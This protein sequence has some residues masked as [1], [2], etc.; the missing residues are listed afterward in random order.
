MYAFSLV[1]FSLIRLI[2]RAPATEPKKGRG[3]GFFSLPSRGHL[4]DGGQEGT[5]EKKGDSQELWVKMGQWSWLLSRKELLQ[6]WP[7]KEEP[8][9]IIQD[10]LSAP[11]ATAT[12]STSGM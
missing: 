1:H 5:M 8:E 4:G 6:V 10:P 2:C 12:A 9:S 11:W 3:D 7:L